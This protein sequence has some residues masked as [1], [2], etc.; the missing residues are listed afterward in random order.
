MRHLYIIC[1][2]VIEIELQLLQLTGEVLGTLKKSKGVTR[3][4]L[5]VLVKL[6]E[7]ADD[8]VLQSSSSIALF[9]CV[10]CKY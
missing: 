7:Q 4:I 1:I 6:Y 10:V 2:S 5:A 8:E 9:P 3:A